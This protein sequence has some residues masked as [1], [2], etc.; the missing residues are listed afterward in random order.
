MRRAAALLPLLAAGC[1]AR[2]PSP[3]TTEGRWAEERDRWTRSA[4]LYDR[5]DEVA[6]ATA[7]YQALPVRLARVDRLAA[8]KGITPE[9]RAA[10]EAQERAEAA[11]LEDFFLAFYAFDRKANDLDLKEG[12]WRVALRVGDGQ[13]LPASIALVPADPT[14]AVLYPYVASFDTLY[15]VRFP[16]WRGERPLAETPFRLE[17]AGA[18]GR[19]ELDF[20]PPKPGG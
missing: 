7:T 9:E 19:I 12:T 18:L 13:V 14:V 3:P 4:K 2:A 16:A 6:F 20:A 5:L 17:I 8:W 1:L 15:R 11:Q 10:L